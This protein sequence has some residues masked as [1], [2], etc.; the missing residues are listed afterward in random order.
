MGTDNG[1]GECQREDIRYRK[2]PCDEGEYMQ[3]KSVV[4]EQ[5]STQL[6]LYCD[7]QG[8]YM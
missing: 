4:M 3:V 6:D 5:M 7:K 2:P 1:S 8:E